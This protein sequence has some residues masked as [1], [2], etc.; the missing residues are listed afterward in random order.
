[1]ISGCISETPFIMENFGASPVFCHCLLLI[2]LTS[3][4]Q[5]KRNKA[6]ATQPAQL[7]GV[8]NSADMMRPAGLA[9]N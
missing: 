8:A 7:S 3:A 5:S 2:M 6:F 4:Y 9:H 1:M